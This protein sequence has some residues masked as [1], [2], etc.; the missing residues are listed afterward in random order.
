MKLNPP[1]PRERDVSDRPKGLLPEAVYLLAL[2]WFDRQVSAAGG[3]YLWCRFRIASGVYSGAEFYCGV[4]VNLGKVPTAKRWEVWSEALGLHEAVELG[5]DADIARNFLGRVFKAL[6]LAKDMDNGR[7]MNDLGHISYARH[8]T[9]QDRETALEWER[10]YK[11]GFFG[12][13]VTNPGE[14]Y[15]G[16]GIDDGR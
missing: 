3:T 4:S 14:R 6:V 11:I 15:V 9:P 13:Q 7:S 8:Y 2:V 1:R 16:W 5:D 12:P 10:L